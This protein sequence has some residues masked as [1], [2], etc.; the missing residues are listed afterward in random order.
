MP[1]ATLHRI[2]EVLPRAELLQTYGL[3]EVGVLRSRLRDQD[4]LWVR[5]GGEGFETKVVDGTL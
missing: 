2:R 1:E 5:V 4:S 3:S